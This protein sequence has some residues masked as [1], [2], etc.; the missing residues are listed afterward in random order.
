MK[1]GVMQS[2]AK[3]NTVVLYICTWMCVNNVYTNVYQVN[4]LTNNICP[5]NLLIFRHWLS[6][7]RD[8]HATNWSKFKDWP[9]L[10]V[11][12]RLVHQWKCNS[13]DKKIVLA[14]IQSTSVIDY[15]ETNER[16]KSEYKVNEW[17]K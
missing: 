5:L 6:L 12:Q 2:A 3:P 4:G 9:P 17:I 8:I 15:E 14:G 11:F 13:Y 7:P 10:D 1:K 16:T